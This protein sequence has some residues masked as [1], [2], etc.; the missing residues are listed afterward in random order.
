[1]NCCERMEDSLSREIYIGAIKY[2]ITHDVRQRPIFCRLSQYFPKDVPMNTNDLVYIDCGAFTGDSIAQIK[3]NT[4][5]KFKK[6]IAFEPSKDNYSVIV[7]K[8]R[9]DE[10]II[11]YC[12]G[13]WDE[14]TSLSFESENFSD[15]KATDGEGQRLDVVAIDTVKECRNASYIKMDIEGAEWNTLHGARTTIMNNKPILAISIYHQDCD[16]V[17]IIEWID[18][19]EMGYKFYVRHHSFD[20]SDTVLYAI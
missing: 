14:N 8:Y 9:K 10:R 19:L 11:A 20:I 4:N 12:L 18:S 6:I 16:Y 13:T 3:K 2:R 17:R 15:M 1:M 7:K 5:N